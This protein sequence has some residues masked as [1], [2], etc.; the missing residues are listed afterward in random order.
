[1]GKGAF[2][3]PPPTDG[4]PLDPAD[5]EGVDPFGPSRAESF[6]MDRYRGFH[7]AG[8]DYS[9]SPARGTRDESSDKYE[10]E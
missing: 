6:S 8:R 2:L 5:P 9:C 10:D 7:P 4:A 1:M 3:R